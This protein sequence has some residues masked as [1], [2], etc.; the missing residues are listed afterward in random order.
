MHQ[1]D[2]TICY[3][4]AVGRADPGLAGREGS[5]A[6][7]CMPVVATIASVERLFEPAVT[8]LLWRRSHQPENACLQ[9]AVAALGPLDYRSV[10]TVSPAGQVNPRLFA[11]ALPALVARDIGLLVELVALLAGVRRVGVRLATLDRRMCPRFHFDRVGLRAT[12]AYRGPGTEWLDPVDVDTS[13][14]GRPLPAGLAQGDPVLRAGAVPH[15]AGTGDVLFMKGELGVEP[16]TLPAVHR[17]PH[18]SA[19]HQR[20]VLTLDPLA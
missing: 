6:T 2:D 3:S 14:L 15:A 9:R 8:A 4:P 20:V 12:C 10:V 16:G 13:W 17:S 1:A 18:A 5:A 11:G 19:A 7:A